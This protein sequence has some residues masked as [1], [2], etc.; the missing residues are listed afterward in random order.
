MSRGNPPPPPPPP[1]PPIG[2]PANPAGRAAVGTRE[3]AGKKG[4]TSPA[5]RPPANRPRKAREP[6]QDLARPIGHQTTRRPATTT[7][8]TA[9]AEWVLSGTQNQPAVPHCAATAPS[10]EDA[11][12]WVDLTNRAHPADIARGKVEVCTRRIRTD[13]VAR[14][15][16]LM[17]PTGRPAGAK[18]ATA[19][20]ATVTV[21]TV[22]LLLLLHPSLLRV[23]PRSHLRAPS[24]HEPRGK[25][26]IVALRVGADP[27]SLAKVGLRDRSARN[28]TDSLK[29]TRAI[30]RRSRNDPTRGR[31]RRLGRSFR[32]GS[33]SSRI[34]ND[35]SRRSSSIIGLQALGIRFI[36]RRSCAVCGGIDNSCSGKRW[37]LFGVV[38]RVSLALVRCR[39]VRHHRR[40][41]HRR[42]VQVSLELAICPAVSAAGPSF[43]PL[44]PLGDGPVCRFCS[45]RKQHSVGQSRARF[46]ESLLRFEPSSQHLSPPSGSW[47]STALA[48]T[49][50][51]HGWVKIW[52]SLR[53]QQMPVLCR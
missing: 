53:C 48:R 32:L 38:K 22:L 43:P 13:P 33:Q 37:L 17:V 23:H 49:V 29:E 24:A 36:R 42:V 52:M 30:T 46:F 45:F 21:S 1:P 34:R 16:V 7:V 5:H 40:R 11:R 6:S 3:P 19:A 20:V 12:A 8:T 41:H 4:A 9:T 14:S 28:S 44:W 39:I 18:V 2:G 15:H 26:V 31:N 25:V 27:V 35:F 51:Q 47:S 10:A 50:E